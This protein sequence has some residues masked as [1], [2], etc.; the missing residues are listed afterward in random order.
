LRTRMAQLRSHLTLSLRGHPDQNQGPGPEP[1]QGYGAIPPTRR[2]R[3]PN[4]ITIAH[5]VGTEQ[6]HAPGS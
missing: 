2:G 6:Y 4:V 1:G 3:H 5:P